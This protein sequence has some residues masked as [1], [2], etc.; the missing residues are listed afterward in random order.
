MATS[1]WWTLVS[2][3]S[4]SPAI[5]PGPSVGPRS[6]WLRRS[7]S[8]KATTKLW[9]SGLLAVSCM[10]CWLEREWGLKP[11]AYLNHITLQ[12]T[13]L[14]IGSNEGLQHHPA[15]LRPN[16]HAQ[17]HYQV[18]DTFLLENLIKCDFLL[19][20]PSLSW[21]DSAEKIQR[22]GWVTRKMESK[23]SRNTNGSR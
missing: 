2:P 21:K 14:R 3:R 5:R 15:R 7:Y 9:T 18:T 23:T 11:Q 20:M 13:F 4:L 10:S 6:T 12:A 8:T 17:T 22:K 16:T 19:E 1:S